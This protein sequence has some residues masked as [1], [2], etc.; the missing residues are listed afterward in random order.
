MA[1]KEQ[2]YEVVGSAPLKRGTVVTVTGWSANLR[3]AYVTCAA[4]PHAPVNVDAL[5]EV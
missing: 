3:T 1:D 2:R 5:R 4:S